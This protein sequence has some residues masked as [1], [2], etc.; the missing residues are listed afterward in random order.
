[1]QES[2]TITPSGLAADYA[3][4]AELLNLPESNQPNQDLKVAAVKRWLQSNSGWLLI[5]DN[6]DDTSLVQPYLPANS[7]GHAI[8]TTRAQSP[9]RFARRTSH[10][11]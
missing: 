5:F 8:L 1:M 3:T 11:C 9:G 6:A 10:G 7:K 2:S 4:I